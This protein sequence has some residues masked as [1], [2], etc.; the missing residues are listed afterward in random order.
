MLEVLLKDTNYRQ[1]YFPC[2]ES[3]TNLLQRI[4]FAYEVGTIS[5]YSNRIC[6]RKIAKSLSKD[7]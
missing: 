6:C 2:K 7:A 3:D 5:F 4:Y 1:Q